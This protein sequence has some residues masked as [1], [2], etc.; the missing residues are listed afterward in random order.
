VR[1]RTLTDVDARQRPLTCAVWM[2]L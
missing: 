1:Q 2:G